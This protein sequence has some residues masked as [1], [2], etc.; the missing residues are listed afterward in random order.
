M[1]QRASE[2]DRPDDTQPG[3]GPFRWAAAY[4]PDRG[5]LPEAHAEAQ[6]AADLPQS[7]AGERGRGPEIPGG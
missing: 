6:Q 3:D 5:A 1:V 7:E 4:R 2:G